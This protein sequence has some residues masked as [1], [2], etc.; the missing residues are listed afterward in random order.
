[1]ALQRPLESLSDDDLLSRLASVASQAR[2]VEVDLVAHIAEVDLR[3]L[4][5]RFACPSMFVYCTR[6]LHLAEGE[7]FRRIRVARASRRHPILLEML[8]DGRLHV[9]GISV[10][11]PILTSENR[12][13]LLS[14]AV[15]RT[16][17]EIQKLVVERHPRL[18]VPPVMRKLPN[19][20]IAQTPGEQSRT[21]PGTPSVDLTT[22]TESNSQ[23]V[24]D[25]TLALFSD[26][27]PRGP[28][29]HV[30]V[31]E[32]LSLS[33]YKIQFTAGQE[34]HDDLERLRALL[35]SEVPDGDL[36]AIVGRAVREL[37]NRLEAR[38]FGLTHAPR[39]ALATTSTAPT[40]R[41]APAAIRR[42]VYQ[43]DAS[44]CRF[45]DEQGRRC[46]ER[47]QVEY[48]H[49]HPFGLGGDHDVE[50]VRLMCPAH[51]RY[52]AEIDYGKEAI[53]RHIEQRESGRSQTGDRAGG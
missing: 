49:G 38:R 16:K 19:K 47:H 17:R 51:N 28:V 9:S 24:S 31:V 32:P 4:W 39:K 14:R 53:S 15:H 8:A 13:S 11:V 48:H 25:S 36:A 46:P 21:P 5:A 40:S 1:M 12:D 3:R 35:R 20:P 33:R 30:P 26:P 52:L 42:A 43:R 6:I 27:A 29:T 10:L 34:L 37:R 22:G 45:V 2:R 50:N 7:A 41:Q 18:D 44:Q 23:P